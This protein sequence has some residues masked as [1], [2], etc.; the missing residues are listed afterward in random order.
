MGTGLVLQG[1]K[2]SGEGLY[3]HVNAVNTTAF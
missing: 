2:S 1:K 3:D